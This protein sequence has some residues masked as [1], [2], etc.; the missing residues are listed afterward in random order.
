MLNLATKKMKNKFI[1]TY[2]L[3]VA[4]PRL[5]FLLSLALF[6]FLIFSPKISLASSLSYE[7]RGNLLIEVEN[8]G[9]AW[10]VDNE[11]GLRHILNSDSFLETARQNSLGISNANLLKIPVAVDSRLIRIDSDRDGLDDRLEKALGTDPLN[12]DSDG[13]SYGDAL[14][15]KHHYNPLGTGRLPIDLNFTK[16]LS[17]QFLLQVE[18]KGELWY[19]SP[20]DNL[21]YYIGDY[22]DLV[23][24]VSLL[25]R[26]INNESINLIADAR[27]ISKGAVKNIKVDVGKKQRVYYYLGE[28]QI[29]SFPVS[30]GKA[31]MPTPKG[32]FSIINKHPKAWSSYGL[33]MPYW[34]G[35]G[36]GHFGFHELP[37][38]P[39]GYREGEDHL[40]IAVSHG[41]IRLGVGPAEFLYKW[42]PVGTKVLIY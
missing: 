21:R 15:L 29:G 22:D 25:G 28:T 14:E 6:S 40:G 5:S 30:A 37:V 10:Y 11:N 2:N 18:G 26:G 27:L 9:Q 32:E 13:D 17:G 41:C 3:K 34:Q 35:L 23:K 39:S 31:S 4:K 36:T 20:R 7:L 38:W 33:W 19:L 42:A 12:S 24:I 1:F 8:R 16:K